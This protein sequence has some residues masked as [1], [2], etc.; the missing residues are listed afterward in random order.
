MYHIKLWVYDDILA[1]GVSG[2][3]DVFTAANTI[4]ARRRDQERR[5]GGPFG[6][7]VESLDGK[8][9]RTASGQIVHVDGTI[10]ARMAADAVIVTAPFVP[11][12][13]HFLDERHDSLIP[14]LSCLRRQHERGAL[15]A[16]YCNGSFPVR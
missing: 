5:V 2:P 3:I 1:S 13:L 7:R 6:W 16:T 8:P 10:N 14:L 12:L 4:W 11:D 15:L 9:V